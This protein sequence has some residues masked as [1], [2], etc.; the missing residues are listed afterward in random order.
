M[1]WEGL[2]IQIRGLN[3]GF[4]EG[5]FP[6]PVRDLRDHCQLC[7]GWIIFAYCVNLLACRLQWTKVEVGRIR[8]DLSKAAWCRQLSQKCSMQSSPLFFFN[9]DQTDRCGML[10][11]SLS[12]SLSASLSPSLL[13]RY[14][15][16]AFTPPFPLQIIPLLISP[17]RPT[18]ASARPKMQKPVAVPTP[19]IP[20]PFRATWQ[21]EIHLERISTVHRLET[22]V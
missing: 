9:A 12:L 7:A 20:K 22:N 14:I 13:K 21:R 5:I 6:W 19:Q 16:I 3:L 10:S 4:W 2:R 1:P 15:Q 11:L 18:T 8:G 17:L